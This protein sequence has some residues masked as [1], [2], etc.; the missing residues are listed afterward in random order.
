MPDRVSHTGWTIRQDEDL[1]GLWGG[2]GWRTSFVQRTSRE[3]CWVPLLARSHGSFGV[4][5]FGEWYSSNFNGTALT[6][7]NDENALYAI[8]V[9]DLTLSELVLGLSSVDASLR[10]VASRTLVILIARATGEA[11]R[12]RG[13]TYVEVG[14]RWIELA[15][16]S[17][18]LRE[19]LA[20][21]VASKRGTQRQRQLARRVLRDY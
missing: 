14:L 8:P 11:L 20:S 12:Q 5:A 10:E 17:D 6:L 7:L 16:R 13:Q 15:P 9:L 1:H 2:S 21:L 3:V 19:S 18:A 4:D